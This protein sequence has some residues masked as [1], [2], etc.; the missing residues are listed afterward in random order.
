[1]VVVAG[2]AKVL[3]NFTIVS[4]NGLG[5]LASSQWL[6]ITVATGERIITKFVPFASGKS[7]EGTFSKG[8][9]PSNGSHVVVLVLVLGADVGVS[10]GDGD[11][12]SG[13]GGS[14][15]PRK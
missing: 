10:D 2:R 14:G 12:G 1:M 3:A 4:G 13:S 5:S 7:N 9:S 15:V 11:G 8:C 6:R